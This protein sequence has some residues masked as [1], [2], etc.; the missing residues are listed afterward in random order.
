MRHRILWVLKYFL[1]LIL[2]LVVAYGALILLV[3]PSLDRDWSRDQMVLARAEI[4][5]STVAITN[6]RN[7]DYRTTKDYDLH[8]YDKTFDLNKLES[9]WFMVEPFSGHGAGA[10]HTLLSFGFAGGD[11][12]AIS[13]EIRKEKGES[14]SPIKGILRQYE[15]VYVIADERDVIK[16][17]SN[18]RKDDVF[19]YPV[20]T[21]KENMRKL[22]VSMLMRANKLATEPEFYNTLTSTCTTNLVAHANEIVS[23]RVPLSYK[24]LMPAYS[25]E[26]AREIGLI[27]NTLTIEELRAKY[28]INDKAMK[29]A[30]DPLFSEHI[31]E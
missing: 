19:L 23:G 1:I 9:V 17:R 28:R 11:Y 2:L 21:T 14:F 30:D 18:Y 4:S 22:F 20:N 29:Y 7:I 3:R 8:Y 6:I 27:D 15:L 16:L 31:R 24:I 26:L 10:A 13:V 25:D 5:G 12:V